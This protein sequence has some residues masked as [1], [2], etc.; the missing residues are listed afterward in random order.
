MGEA[1]VR[2]E[3]SAGRVLEPGIRHSARRRETSA[4]RGGDAR[5]CAKRN[6]RTPD[7]WWVSARHRGRRGQREHCPQRQTAT[8]VCRTCFM[9]MVPSGHKTL[10][11]YPDGNSGVVA[12][13][14][15]PVEGQII[16]HGWEVTTVA[17]GENTGAEAGSSTRS[18]SYAQQARRLRIEPAGGGVHAEGRPPPLHSVRASGAT[19]R[20]AELSGRST[21]LSRGT[22]LRIPHGS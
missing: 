13:Y 9:P 16:A 21:S 1:R 12:L 6:S 17:P 22:S 8:N 2:P 4:R 15:R 19:R 7:S 20:A 3:R 11:L 10:V 14:V 18:R 5:P